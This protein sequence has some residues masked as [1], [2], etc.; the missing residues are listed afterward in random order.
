MFFLTRFRRLFRRPNPNGCSCTLP[1]SSPANRRVAEIFRL[2]GGI[3]RGL[4][5]TARGAGLLDIGLNT[6]GEFPHSSGFGLVYGDPYF[7]SSDQVDVD[8]MRL[9]HDETIGVNTDGS[10]E[11]AHSHKCWGLLP[12]VFSR[13]DRIDGADYPKSADHADWLEGPMLWSDHALELDHW[14]HVHAFD[15][16]LGVYLL[17]VNAKVGLSPGEGVDFLLGLFGIDIAQDDTGG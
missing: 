17:V 8:F 6:P 16:E 9:I 11:Y 14:A 5:V 1:Y 4:G 2:Q 13:I 12:A 10:G 7:L 15:A 3:G